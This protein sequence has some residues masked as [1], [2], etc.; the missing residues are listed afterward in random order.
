M[1]DRLVFVLTVLVMLVHC[2]VGADTIDVCSTCSQ[3]SIRDA[4][5]DAED[6]D[7]IQLAAETYQESGRI[8]TRNKAITILGVTDANGTPLS[9]IDGSGTRGV[10]RI[11]RGEGPDTRLENLI[12]QN[13]NRDEGAG[14]EIDGDSAP[15]FVNCIFQDNEGSNGAGVYVNSAGAGF[16][17]CTFR[18]NDADDKGGA[19]H[20]NSAESGVSLEDCDIL[21]NGAKLGA[22]I[23]C[24]SADVQLIRCLVTS[25]DADDEGGGISTN[26]TDLD[27]LDTIV[28]GNSP[29]QIHG[30]WDDEGG[31]CVEESCAGCD[32]DSDG[33]GVP[34]S[35]DGCVDDPLKSDPGVCGC[36]EPDTDSDKDGIPD[37]IDDCPDDADNDADGDGSCEDLPP[38]FADLDGNRLVDG[39]DLTILLDAWGTDDSPADLDESGV[40]GALDLAYLLG[41]WGACPE[42]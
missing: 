6:G 28:C 21:D 4:I 7:V 27:L 40:V 37:C 23:W 10:F 18:R 22:G 8:D 36:G 30:D 3:T 11:T 39:N 29:D 25:N 33:D 34:D 15:T 32:L 20:L 12:I 5:D 13:G 42:R 2:K 17:G 38:C 9:I 26:S 41:A 31:N 14:V 16:H 1:N 19:L 24:N 35:E